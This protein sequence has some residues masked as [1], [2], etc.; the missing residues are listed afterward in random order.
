MLITKGQIERPGIGIVVGSVTEAMSEANGV[1]VGALVDSVVKDGPAAAAGIKAGDIIVEANGQKV[2]K[3]TELIELVK[4]LKI[5][6]Q[7][8]LHIYRE[9]KYMDCTIIVSNKSEMNF[10]AKQE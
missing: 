8:V 10:D 4:Q 6:D 9:G 7:F 2:T 3:Q 1:P 5:G